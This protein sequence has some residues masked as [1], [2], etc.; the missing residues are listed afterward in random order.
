MKGINFSKIKL[1]IGDITL[2]RIGTNCVDSA[3]NFLGIC[4]DESLTL[5]KHLSNLNS[6]ISRAIF[7]TN[8]V[9]HYLPTDSMKI[10]YFSVVHPH[11]SCGILA[12]GNANPAVLNKT[13]K[14]QNKQSVLLI[15]RD[16]IVTLTPYSKYQV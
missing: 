6:K 15:M 12:W 11:L 8:R 4:I 7:S 9:K 5:K 10:L 14:L 2:D 16:T 1:K 13:I 3:T